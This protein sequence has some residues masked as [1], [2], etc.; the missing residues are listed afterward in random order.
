VRHT[1]LGV[2]LPGDTPVHRLD[3]RVKLAVALVFAV[4]LFTTRS[5]L[6]LLAIGC[7]VLATIV[8]GRIP[9]AAAA[10]GVRAV[11]FILVFTV[12]AQ[13]L[14]WEP[15]TAMMRLGP[16]G[17][18]AEGLVTGMLFAFR[19][20]LL[21]VG[22]SVVTLTTTP[23]EL[24][25]ALEW[26]MRPLARIGLPAHDIAMMLS[27]ALRF[28]PLTAEVA[29][30]VLTAQRARGAR[31]DRGGL[32]ARARAW[33]PVLVPLF[34]DLFRRADRLAHAME[35]RC[36]RG[37]ASRTRLNALAM[38]PADWVVFVSASSALVAI[39]AVLGRSSWPR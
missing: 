21:V 12:L 23:V 30:Q 36:Y 17:F 10:R 14:R 13:T 29:D 4:A 2:Y 31:F 1:N 18:S 19:I 16:V 15:A 34:V 39:V 38:R 11:A 25:D 28:V 32:V 33:V 8:L 27:I 26:S 22:T 20:L 5:W 24:T 3:P 35:A 6:A 37:G 9:L 7:L